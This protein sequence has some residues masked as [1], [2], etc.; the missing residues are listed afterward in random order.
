MVE[1]S[2][3]R[4]GFTKTSAIIL[5]TLI[6]ELRQQVHSSAMPIFVIGFLVFLMEGSVPFAGS[7]MYSLHRFRFV[8]P[9]RTDLFACLTCTSYAPCPV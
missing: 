9:E 4:D 1:L 3:I 8:L 7:H 5:A 6:H 2:K